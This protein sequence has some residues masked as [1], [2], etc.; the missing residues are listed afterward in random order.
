MGPMGDMLPQATGFERSSPPP[1]SYN[2]KREGIIRNRIHSKCAPWR[3]EPTYHAI[4]YFVY[5]TE[6]SDQQITHELSI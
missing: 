4:S 2:R 5:S 6:C 1:S 3:I